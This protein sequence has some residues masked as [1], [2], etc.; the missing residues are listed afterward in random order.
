MTTGRIN[1]ITDLK[2]ARRAPEGAATDRFSR[3]PPAPAGPL[4]YR[5]RKRACCALCSTF[6]ETLRTTTACEAIGVGTFLNLR[7]PLP[8]PEPQPGAIFDTARP[9]ANYHTLPR[10]M[11]GCNRDQTLLLSL[12]RK[13]TPQTA[14]RSIDPAHFE[15]P[16]WPTDILQTHATRSQAQSNCA[17]FHSHIYTLHFRPQEKPSS[18]GCQSAVSTKTPQNPQ[19]NLISKSYQKNYFFKHLTLT[20]TLKK[21]NFPKIG[22]E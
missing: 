1:Q 2:T 15:L 20:L 9:V 16:A 21:K 5:R 11:P 7:R 10:E 22:P 13:R 18:L 12:R 14:Q 17:R 8:A 3:R 4:F 19:K 6:F